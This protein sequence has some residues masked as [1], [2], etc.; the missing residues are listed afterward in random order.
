MKLPSD[1]EAHEE[2]ERF[3]V[4]RVQG[5]AQDGRRSK[6]YTW[7]AP[8]PSTGHRVAGDARGGLPAAVHTGVPIAKPLARTPTSGPGV[9]VFRR[10]PGLRRRGAWSPGGRQGRLLGAFPARMALIWGA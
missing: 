5:S 1:T 7:P 9:V 8:E 10:Q 3:D 6:L 4:V 2:V